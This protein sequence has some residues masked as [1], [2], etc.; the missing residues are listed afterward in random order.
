MNVTFD[1]NGEVSGVIT[2]SIE[3]ADYEAKVTEKLKEIGKKHTIPGFRK[4]HISIGELRKRFGREVKSDAINDVVIDAAW[5]FIS[6]NKIR[7]IGQPIPA[8]EVKEIDPKQTDYTFK[9]DVGIWPA[10][11][12]KLDKSVTLPMYK[13]EVTDQMIEEQDKA[14]C[15]RFGTQGPG[16]EVD[17]KA[18]IKGTIMELNEDGSVK[19]VEDAIQVVSGMVAPFLFKDKEEAAKFLGKH[20][21]E[22]VVFNPAKSCEGNVAELSAMLNLDKEQAAN[23]KSDFELTISEIVVLKPA[24]HEQEFY[25]EVFGKDKVSSEE[26]YRAAVKSMIESQLLPNSFEM[27]NRDIH[28]YLVNTYSDSVVFDEDFL[29]RWILF[30]NKDMTNE[31]LEEN[32]DEFVKSFK[33]EVI[34]EEANTVLKV[35][36]TEDDYFARASMYARQQMQQYGMYNMDE[37]TVADMAKRLLADRQI[38]QQIVNECEDLAMYNAIRNAITIEEKVVSV[39]EF[40]ELASAK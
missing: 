20:V 40:K 12:L 4:G 38:R 22:K 14:L 19:D 1:K 6:E 11:E 7:T 37:E 39:E 27:S 18:I 8:Q 31:K 15:E 29:K 30:A 32:Y 16:E 25:D 24:E 36:L 10:I 2:V 35:E 28:E 17:A 33:W 34:S 23:V 21:D 5:N 9:F 13:I 3:Q 26:E